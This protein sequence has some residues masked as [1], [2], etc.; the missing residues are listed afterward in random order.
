MI[1]AILALAL[2]A[3]QL[4]DF[5]QQLTFIDEENT[6]KEI[7]V[8]VRWRP[9]LRLARKLNLHLAHFY[10]RKLQAQQQE[11]QVQE[12][13]AGLSH[14]IRTPLTSL[15]GYLQL[16]EQ[17]EDE[18]EKQRY[19]QVLHL[20]IDSLNKILTQLFTYVK[21]QQE[22]YSLNL[23]AVNLTDLAAH[24]LFSFYEDFKQQGFDLSIDFPDTALYVQGQSEALGRV[25]QNIF[26]NALHHGSS[27]VQ[28]QLSASETEAI[29]RCNNSMA[30]DVRLEEDDVFRQFYK[31]DPARGGSSTGLGLYIAKKLVEKMGGR[32]EVE[33]REQQFNL[34]LAL[35][36]AQNS[37]EVKK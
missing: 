2:V 21:L 32:L 36:L 14:D 4:N 17:A 8:K 29:F 34:T 37:Q 6:R 28:V 11:R 5:G 3:Y 25:L 19:F 16:L 24:S 35:Q 15:E 12:T 31:A 27:I 7:Q 20:R 13:L 33:I 1:L 23:E 10:Q 30:K 26:V 22:T 18:A 9:L